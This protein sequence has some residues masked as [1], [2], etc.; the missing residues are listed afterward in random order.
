MR[1]SPLGV[2]LQVR[3]S[4]FVTVFHSLHWA[5]IES[6]SFFQTWRQ[7]ETA[8]SLLSRSSSFCPSSASLVAR[9]S[10][11]ACFVVSS[12]I[13]PLRELILHEVNY[14]TARGFSHMVIRGNSELF[15]S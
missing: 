12:L 4:S 8:A 5:K 9:N 3:D 1:R 6:L 15:F 7:R 11:A 2:S 10:S 14:Q 13:G